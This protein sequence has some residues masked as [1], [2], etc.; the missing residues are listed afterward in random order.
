MDPLAFP[1]R[2]IAAILLAWHMKNRRVF[3][4]RDE[5][6][7]YR[8][9]V[10]EFFLQRTPANRVAKFYPSFL[11]EF[12]SPETL[13]AA[14][15]KYLEQFGRRLGLK[16]RMTWLL[17]S[18]KMI[19]REYGGKVPH[20]SEELMKLPG[21]GSYTASAV[22]CFGFRRNISIVDANV[23]RV[24]TRIFGLPKPHK[25]NNSAIQETAREL[26]PKGRAAAY[27]EALLDFAA[28]LCKKL[29]QC[30]MCPLTNLCHYYQKSKVASPT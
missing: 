9:L 3:P 6:E 23:V 15:P 19:C 18:A 11:K 14:D 17:D 27:N 10:A 1:E 26:I 30:D 28:I 25:V 21:V 13:A 22:L 12:P 4:W 16:K 2:D 7:P 20:K 24:V 29:P 8:V 5:P